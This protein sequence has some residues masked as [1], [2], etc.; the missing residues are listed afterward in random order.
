MTLDNA[1]KDTPLGTEIMDRIEALAVISESPEHLTRRY[2]TPEH[3][4]ANDLVASWMQE[5]GMTVREDAVGN[6]I[7]RYPGQNPNAQTL[8]LGSHLDTVVMAGKYD[9]ILGV[10]S[11]IACV[12]ALY[13]KGKRL[14][15]AVEVI[16]F[17]DEEGA[18]FQSTL[19]GSR[20]VAG[21]FDHSLLDREDEN[22]IRMA[23]AMTAFGLD[24]DCI[25]EAARR[26]EELL[27]YI[28]LH[29][30]QGPV[31]EDQD[32]ATGVVTAIAG[33]NRFV[34]TLTGSAGHAGTVPMEL[35]HDAFLAAAECSLVVEEVVRKQGDSVGT[36]G[37]LD[38]LPGA[39]NVIPG[40]VTFTVDLRAARDSHRLEASLEI[41]RQWNEIAMRRGVKIH[42]EIVHEASSVQCAPH[43]RHQIAAAVVHEEGR[44]LEL[45]SGAGHDAAGMSAVTDVGM[46]FVRCTGGISHNPDE[47]ISASDAEAGTRVMLN[48]IENFQS[49]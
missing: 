26:P 13:D 44:V 28:E 3:R 8:I 19:L 40:Q 17:G 1:I 7:G 29:I 2:L 32:M 22:G 41:Q 18:R 16:G 36:V 21:T 5:S 24:P 20:A 31:L 39:S 23:D 27:A 14:P 38:V 9:G 12:G 25:E 45:P 15:F 34:V 46:I 43:L 6:I 42:T 37:R 33:A 48:V 47:A 4:Q 35:R 49:V 11:G 30:E 10:V